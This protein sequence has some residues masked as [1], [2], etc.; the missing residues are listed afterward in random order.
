MLF[1]IQVFTIVWLV[2]GLGFIF[3]INLLMMDHMR[4]IS[5][6][7]MR[8]SKKSIK[9]LRKFAKGS[10]EGGQTRIKEISQRKTSL[11]RVNSA[12]S[13]CTPSAFKKGLDMCLEE[14]GEMFVQEVV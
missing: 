8:S 12:P 1:T 6:Q 5:K 13:I 3:M 9:K 4:G 2:F 14:D 11:K 10:V 7:L